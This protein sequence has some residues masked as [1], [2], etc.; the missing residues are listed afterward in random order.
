M[1]AVCFRNAVQCVLITETM[2]IVQNHVSHSESP[3]IHHVYCHNTD[4]Q[5]LWWKQRWPRSPQLGTISLS[6][7][8]NSNKWH[9][10]VNTLKQK[11]DITIFI[12]LSK[13]MLYNFIINVWQSKYNKQK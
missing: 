9:Y 11:Q 13:R 6:A 5:D 7:K 3:S 4:D 1:K 10:C 2:G 8:F 12:K